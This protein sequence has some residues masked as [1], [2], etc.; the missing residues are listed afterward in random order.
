MSISFRYG[1]SEH[2]KMAN[3][4]NKSDERSYGTVVCSLPP[5]S[6]F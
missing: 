6:R 4:I 3:I 2:K 1:L 5:L